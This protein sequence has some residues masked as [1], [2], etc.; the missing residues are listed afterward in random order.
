[1]GNKH[2][3]C[4]CGN[5]IVFF[6]HSAFRNGVKC[7]GRFVQNHTDGIFIEQS[8]HQEFLLFT[9][10]QIDSLGV[11]FS[12]QRCV[13]FHG[14]AADL[15]CKTNRF[16]TSPQL[17]PV[18]FFLS[19]CAGDVASDR[20]RQQVIVLGNQTKQIIKFIPIIFQDGVSVDRYLATVR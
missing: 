7:C 3:G 12:V 14:Q 17:L 9:T 5:L 6:I 8:C 10:G 13:L 2:R 19:H 1:M 11:D 4:V 20:H 18:N 16:Q 15:F